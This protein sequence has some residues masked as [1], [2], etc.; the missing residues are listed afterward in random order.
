[1]TLIELLCFVL[2]VLISVLAGRCFYAKIGWWGVPL[3][4]IIGFGSLYGLILLLD[5]LFPPPSVREQLRVKAESAKQG[6]APGSDITQ[7]KA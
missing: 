2:G 5:R 7:P 3:A 1:M 6:T 4:P